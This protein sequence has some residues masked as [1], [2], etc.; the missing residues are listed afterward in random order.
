MAG[1]NIEFNLNR[2]LALG[3]R[4]TYNYF[5]VDYV[6][7][8]GYQGQHSQ[9]SKNNDGLVDV[10]L[11]LRIKL[12]AVSKSHVRNVSNDLWMGGYTSVASTPTPAQVP[13]EPAQTIQYVHDT[14]IIQRDSVIIREQPVYVSAADGQLT[15]TGNISYVYFEQ[16]KST[17]RNSGL[18]TIQ[19]VA[20]RMKE[21]PELYAVVVGYCDNTGTDDQ[22]Y[23][24]SDIR[25]G[26]VID[27]LQNEHNIGADHLY[28]C[29]AGRVVGGRSQA[30]Y[31]PNRRAVI[32]LVDKETFDS[33]KK[34][35]EQA[36]AN[37]NK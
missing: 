16:Y 33:L 20:D 36:K 6:D 10:T 8:R 18:I 5:L 35:L 12:A 34:E 4:A 17:L 28:A 26:V 37:R 14:V 19:Q 9:A 7:G 21:F 24:L 22:N 30:A 13:V 25:A 11:N 29:G 15:N 23:E 32:R 31:G 2:T 1:G 3:V 27:E